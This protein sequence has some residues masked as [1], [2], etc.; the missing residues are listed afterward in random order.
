MERR[1]R[2]IKEINGRYVGETKGKFRR[3]TAEAI[4]RRNNDTRTEIHRHSWH[5][6][7]RALL[8]NL[9]VSR[10]ERA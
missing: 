9:Y 10:C 6:E 8:C 2:D 7:A 5:Q 3:G 4:S 1:R